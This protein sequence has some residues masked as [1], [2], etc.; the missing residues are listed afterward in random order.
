M[1]ITTAIVATG[2]S[3]VVSPVG[4]SRAPWLANAI[5]TRD[6]LLQQSSCMT[7]LHGGE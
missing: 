3:S 4:G 5:A 7:G 1:I 2:C 6:V